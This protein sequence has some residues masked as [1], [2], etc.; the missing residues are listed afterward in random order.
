MSTKINI[1]LAAALLTLAATPQ[2]ASAQALFGD[3]PTPQWNAS[4]TINQVPSDARASVSKVQRHR[5]YIP[6][7]TRAS[8]APYAANEG[9]PYT[10]SMPAPRGKNHDFQDSPR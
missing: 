8:V 6:S 9:G 4:Q 7:E 3:N 5:V 2:L 10:P 1:A